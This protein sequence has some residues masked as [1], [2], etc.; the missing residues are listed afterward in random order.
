MQEVFN[1][2]KEKFILLEE[3]AVEAAV[4]KKYLEDLSLI[5]YSNKSEEL[6]DL[7]F[8]EKALNEEHFGMKEVKDAILEIIAVGKLKGSLKGKIFCLV[9]G[10]G[11]GKTTIGPIDQQGP[12]QE[13]L[14]YFF[15]GRD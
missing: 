5:P 15:G 9:G 7:E 11:V 4:A 8:A 13:V 12:G 10:P 14:Q 6:Y 3:T 1:Q 2:E